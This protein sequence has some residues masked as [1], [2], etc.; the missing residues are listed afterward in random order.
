MRSFATVLCWLL[1][2]TA[3]TAQDPA[4]STTPTSS[5]PA[6]AALR[7]TI[8]QDEEK[9][10][11]LGVLFAPISEVLYEHLPQLPRNQGVLVTHVL[12]D[13]PAVHAGLRRFDLLLQYQDHKI[14]DCDHLARLIQADKPDSKVRFIVVRAGKQI[15]V[16]ATLGLG[17]I[18]RIAAT[19]AAP[20]TPPL[21]RTEPP[22][23]VA[24]PGGTAAV[25]VSATPLEPGKMKVSIEFYQE[26][27]GRLRTVVCQ[28]ADEAIDVEVK[29]LP[30]KEQRLVQ[31]ALQRIRELNIRQKP[32]NPVD[33][34]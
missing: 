19:T 23:G 2:V 1:P 10:T 34:R 11:Y 21:P 14:R 18:L 26:G 12:P 7:L 32:E 27:T 31:A 5:A 8:N 3:L 22:R 16:D 33:Q 20:P 6:V 17:P 4:T 15:T 30:E 13:S 24:K 28:G 29:K 25:S 9:G